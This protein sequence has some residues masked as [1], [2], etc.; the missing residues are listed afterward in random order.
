MSFCG[1]LSDVSPIK[2]SK[3][4]KRKY[5]SFSVQDEDSLH[6]GV[7]FSPEKHCLFEKISNDD[8]SGIEIKR[9]KFG[10]NDSDII[11]NDFTSVKSTDVNFT[12]KSLQ[13]RSCTIE[14]VINECP[15]F[16]IV[17]VKG[18]VYNLQDETTVKK[19]DKP[20]RMRKGMIKDQDAKISLVLFD[21]IIDKVENNKF[22]EF[23]KLRVQKFSNERLL[24]STEI[25]TVSEME[26]PGVVVT[27]E[28]S[29]HHENTKIVAKVVKIDLKSLI[30]TFLCPDCSAPVEVENSAAWCNNCEN[31][32]SKSLCKLKSS[33]RMVVADDQSSY[34]ISVSHGL[35]DKL[36]TTSV[37]N[38]SAK[39]ISK[40][41]INRK[42]TFQINKNNEC[43]Q[44]SQITQ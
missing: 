39:E 38:N 27:K 26:N 32:A 1:Y 2:L 24:K 4:K 5:F 34:S 14:Q 30:Q 28:E 22:Y 23:Q 7:C 3:D 31:V 40:K 19:D 8:K 43:I 12:N 6:R 33:A 11:I 37:S 25:T 10:D 20:L 41:L 16:D 9:F 15:I 29:E 17:S 13:L 36:L 35:I 18:L 44:I 42:F 21:V